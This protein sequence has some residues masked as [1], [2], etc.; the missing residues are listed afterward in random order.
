VRASAPLVPDKGDFNIS[1]DSLGNKAPT[2]RNLAWGSFWVQLPLT[3]V[4]A[5][6]LFFAVQFSRAV[7][8]V[9]GVKLV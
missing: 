3:V 1:G 8:P 5:C 9:S 7:R 2:M 6:I 4:S